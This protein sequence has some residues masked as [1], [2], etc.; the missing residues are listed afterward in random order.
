[1]TL[2]FLEDGGGGFVEGGRWRMRRS[3]TPDCDT[4]ETR[5]YTLR[6]SIQHFLGT[7]FR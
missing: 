2:G 4:M 6:I 5:P 3:M 1:M 7:D